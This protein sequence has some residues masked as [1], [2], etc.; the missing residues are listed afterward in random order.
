MS[1]ITIEANLP[2]LPEGWTGTPQE[3]LEWFVENVTYEATGGFLTGQI[4]GTQPT[5]DVGLWLNNGALYVWD[6]NEAEYVPL[7]TEPIG[8]IKSYAGVG[9]APPTDHLFCEGQALLQD[10]YPGLFA[11][12]GTTFNK[13]SD[14]SDEFRLPDLRGRVITGAGQG[15]YDPRDEGASVDTATGR[16]TERTFG[17]YY[18]F[19]W[20]YR[21]YPTQASAPTPRF[22]IP[23]GAQ[24]NGAWYSSV[25]QPACSLRW[26]VRYQ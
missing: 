3:L 26:M 1:T 2:S 23:D 16:I 15:D 5:E 8:T 14:P 13:P 4:G 7:R 9:E 11:I 25:Q 22:R 19:E 24:F 12:V 21:K 18:G 10:D 6:A 20:I 17:E